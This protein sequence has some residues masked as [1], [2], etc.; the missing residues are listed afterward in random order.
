MASSARWPTIRTNSPP[1]LSLCCATPSV[2]PPWRS[3][4]APKWS[5]AGTWPPSRRAWW[6]AIVPWSRRSEDEGV[7]ALVGRSPWT[8]RDAS[9]RLR[10]GV[11]RIMRSARGRRGRRPRTRGS[12]PPLTNH[13]GPCAPERDRRFRLSP[14]LLHFRIQIFLDAAYNVVGRAIHFFRSPTLGWLVC[15]PDHL[16]RLGVHQEDGALGAPERRIRFRTRQLVH[17][18]AQ[19]RVRLVLGLGRLLTLGRLLALGRL[20]RG[21]RLVALRRGEQ[22]LQF[23]LETFADLVREHRV[24]KLRVCHDP[25]DVVRGEAVGQKLVQPLGHLKQV[26][27]V[28]AGQIRRAQ[29]RRRAGEKEHKPLHRTHD[30]QTR[31]AG[32]KTDPCISPSPSP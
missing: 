29:H 14:A 7:R 25:E 10:Y 23:R 26:P 22:L 30:I 17:R 1:G 24:G 16:A 11:I 12:A 21:R 20:R 5:P 31:D 15:R 8:A 6:K 3:A 13:A 27:R 32:K 2:P 19:Q 18:I 4:P 28:H 9:S